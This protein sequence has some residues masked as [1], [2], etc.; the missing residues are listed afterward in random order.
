M[1]LASVVYCGLLTVFYARTRPKLRWEAERFAKKAS[2][3]LASGGRLGTREL[4]GLTPP[5]SL[6]ES[7]WREKLSEGGPA[8]N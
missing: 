2:R 6:G 7:D 3:P 5:G 1:G 4:L 8:E